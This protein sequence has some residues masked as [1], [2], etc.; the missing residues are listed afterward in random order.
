MSTVEERLAALGLVLPP[1]SRPVANYVPAVRSGNLLFLAGQVPR[2]EQGRLVAGRVGDTMDID[3]AYQAA[4]T[5][6]LQAL[7]VVKDDLGDLDRVVRVVR[8]LGLVNAVPDFVEQPAVVNGFSDLMVEAF[9]DA[10][11][12]ARVAYGAGSLP[13]GVPV[14]VESL[15]EVVDRPA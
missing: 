3:A 9:G 4:R 14:E 15:F 8:V 13:G 1:V 5:C 12:H 11:R 6:A 7:A 10:G 2:D